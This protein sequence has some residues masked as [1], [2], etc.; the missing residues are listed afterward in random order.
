[1]GTSTFAVS[2]LFYR[3]GYQLSPRHADI[4]ETRFWR[5]DPKADY[6]PL[7]G[8]ARHKVNTRLI[9]NN[10]DDLLR[11]AGSLKK[12]T[13]SASELIRSLLRSHNPSSPVLKTRVSRLS[14]T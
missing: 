5:I 4:G 13:I 12:G 7:N 11:V 2:Y 6:G 9:Q 8:L 1:M 10:W 3:R 14:A